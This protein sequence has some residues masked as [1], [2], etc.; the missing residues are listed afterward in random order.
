[1]VVVDET[2]GASALSWQFPPGIHELSTRIESTRARALDMRA[3]IRERF[4]GRPFSG[5]DWMYLVG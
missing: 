1:M 4:G 5:D 2:V 3:E